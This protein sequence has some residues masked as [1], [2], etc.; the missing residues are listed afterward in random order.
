MTD[1]CE[2]YLALWSQII[3]SAG[4]FWGGL[5]L[6]DTTLKFS[7]RVCSRKKDRKQGGGK[8]NNILCT[9]Y[10]ADSKCL[11]NHHRNLLT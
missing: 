3:L 8:G 7:G 4:D 6:K 11:F 1:Q 5:H 10:G 2:L 9:N